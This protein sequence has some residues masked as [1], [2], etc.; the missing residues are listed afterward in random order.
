[1][2]EAVA[3]A[4]EQSEKKEMDT[5]KLQAAVSIIT[6]YLGRDKE[7]KVAAVEW[8]AVSAAFDYV[9]KNLR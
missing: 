7:L 8:N 3:K 4:N 5:L 2:L 6:A 1:M 9:A